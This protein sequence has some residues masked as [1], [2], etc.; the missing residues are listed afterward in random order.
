MKNSRRIKCIQDLS[1]YNIPLYV[2]EDI[3]RRMTDWIASGGNYDDHYIDQQ[4]LYAERSIVS[5]RG[6]V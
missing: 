3:N 2:L 6:V 5:Q 4:L 1:L